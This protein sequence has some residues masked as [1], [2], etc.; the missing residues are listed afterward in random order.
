MRITV[1]GAGTIGS[2]IAWDLAQRPDISQVQ[3]CDSRPGPLEELHDRVR[4]P[5]LRTFQVNARDPQV[6]TP[7]LKRSQCIVGCVT[8]GI[9]AVVSRTAV[10]LGIHFCDLGGS[11]EVVEEQFKLHEE[12]RKKSV[13]IVPNC[14]LAPGLINIL[15][16]HGV[17]QFDSV[18]SADVRVGA[19]PIDPTPPFN[20]HLSYDA[21]KLVEDYTRPATC[22]AQGEMTR[23][24]PLTGL[25]TINFPEPFGNLEAFHTSGGLSTLP[26]DLEGRIQNLDY[27]TIRYPG[28]AKQMRFLLALG[29]AEERAIDVR[30]HLTYRDILVRRLQKRLRVEEPDVV[31][32]RILITGVKNGDEK[33]LVY[34]MIDRYDEEQ[35]L[36]ATQRCTG[37][38][39]SV[40]A[41]LLASK[42][43]TGGGASPP[44][45]I[46]PKD[47][48]LDTLTERGLDIS[49]NWYDGHLDI[50]EPLQDYRTA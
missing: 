45:H 27:K 31:V 5:K 28:H 7:I 23:C 33:T 44:E 39:V 32:L 13:W 21:S 20:F 14:G 36:T 11:E 35:E 4:S 29:F 9:N 42:S 30:T 6:L 26:S 41:A 16:M 17:D 8:P 34:E 25:E 49:L 19:I 24:Q 2:A 46:V 15:C 40:I 47:A 43:V 50:T 38:P 1:I 22:I 37:F 10:E 18:H 48:F 3:V 12:A